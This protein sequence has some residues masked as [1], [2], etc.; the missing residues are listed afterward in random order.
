MVKKKERYVD[1]ISGEKHPDVN[2]TKILELFDRLANLGKRI[3]MHDTK[4][5][6]SKADLGDCLLKNNL[7]N[8]S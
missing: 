4:S 7:K 1:K 3:R 6:G 5:N 2:E 8:K